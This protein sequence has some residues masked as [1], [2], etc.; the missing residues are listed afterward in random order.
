MCPE[1]GCKFHRWQHLRSWTAE[2]LRKKVE[3]YGFQTKLVT[4]IAWGETFPKRFALKLAARLNMKP[5]SGLVY[6]GQK[7]Q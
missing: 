6:V 1:C 7:L 5:E 3:Q 2:S 4:P